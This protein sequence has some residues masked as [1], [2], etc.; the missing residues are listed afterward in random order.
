M[1]MLPGVR[2][3][4][5]VR[6][7]AQVL[8]LVWCNGAMVQELRLRSPVGECGKSPL[9]AALPPSHSTFP[10]LLSIKPGF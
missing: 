4:F 5:G 8:D 1:C 9:T 10:R 7:E 2:P 3:V 6:P